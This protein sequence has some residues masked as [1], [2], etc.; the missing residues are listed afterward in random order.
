MEH[1]KPV[2]ID[3]VARAAGVAPSTVSKTLN[4]T[5]QR[6]KPTDVQMRIRRI[7]AELGYR[8]NHTARSLS[9]GHTDIIGLYWSF[10]YNA[11]D[12]FFAQLV[13]G[14][15]SS[16]RKYLKDV[17]MHGTFHKHP[18]NDLYEELTDGKTDGLILYPGRDEV[19]HTRLAESNF[20]VVTI[21]EQRPGIPVVRVDVEA[22]A[23]LAAEQLAAR[24]HHRVFYRNVM[25]GW[26]TDNRFPAFCAAASSHGITVIETHVGDWVGALSRQEF[27]LL[28]LPPGQRPTAAVCFNDTFAYRLIAHCF[29]AGLRIPQDLAILGFDGAFPWHEHPQRLTTLYAPWQKVAE[30]AVDLLLDRIDGNTI[31]ME[32][33][34]PVTWQDGET[35]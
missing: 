1:R 22:G 14:L 9:K 13:N 26:S 11:L 15:R 30:T 4:R 21:A 8:P 3:D 28:D 20:P 16:C 25:P 6:R 34:L 5:I 10:D 29:R 17:L 33:V 2:S 7:A 27:E 32:T 24:G 18:L 35:L 23:R 31:A 19:V 12:P